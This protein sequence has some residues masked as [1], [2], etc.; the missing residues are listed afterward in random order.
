VIIELINNITEPLRLP[1]WTPT[2]VIVLLAIGFPVVIIFSWINDI[3]PEEGVVKT[4]PVD[5]IKA[6]DIPK[7]SN[8]WKIASY[9]SFLVI[10]GL[11]KWHFIPRTSGSNTISELNKSIAVLPFQNWSI[12]EAHSHLGNALANEIITEL[13][14]VQDFHVISYTSSAR[15]KDAEDLSISQIGQELGANLSLKVLSNDR[16][17]TSIFMSR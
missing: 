13:Y 5:Q 11:V 16:M 15:F 14:K 17:R 2:L 7:T 9:L 4:E 8:A 12:D 6:E 1:D 10:L 3:H